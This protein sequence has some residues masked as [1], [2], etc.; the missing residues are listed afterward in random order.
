MCCYEDACLLCVEYVL[1]MICDRCDCHVHGNQC[2][3]LTAESTTTRTVQ[4]VVSLATIKKDA[5]QC[6]KSQSSECHRFTALLMGQS[7]CLV[8][9]YMESNFVKTP[10]FMAIEIFGAFFVTCARIKFHSVKYFTFLICWKNVTPVNFF[11]CNLYHWH[12][13]TYIWSVL[14]NNVTLNLSCHLLHLI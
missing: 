6:Q 5:K 2:D 9:V 1:Q 14:A 13:W 4:R 8:S 11:H 7:C 10:G 12:F 3:L